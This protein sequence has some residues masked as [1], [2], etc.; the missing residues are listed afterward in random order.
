MCGIAGFWHFKTGLPATADAVKA[1]TDR[2]EHRGPDGGGEYCN[3]DLGLGQRRLSIIDLAGGHQPMANA[4]EDIWVVFNGEIFNHRALRAELEADGVRFRTSSDT[5]VISHCYQKYGDTFS[6]ALN[7]FFAIALW[8]VKRQR[9]ILTRDRLGK[10]PLLIAHTQHG[11]AFASEMQALSAA[12]GVSKTLDVNGLDAFVSYGYV[13]HRFS[14]YKGVTKL[15]PATT[16]SI[17]RDGAERQQ[18]Y[19]QIEHK[20]TNL[21]YEDAKSALSEL[22]ATAVADRLESDV[23][24]GAF[25]S[26]GIDSTTIA[27]Y[28]SEQSTEQL[29][30][31]CVGFNE[32]RFDERAPARMVAEWLGT[33]HRESVVDVDAAAVLPKLL[34]HYGEPYSDAS[35]IP[36]YFL[37]SAVR[38]HMT[39]ALSGDGGD[40][41]FLGYP[42]YPKFEKRLKLNRLLNALPGSGLIADVARNRSRHL[43]NLPERIINAAL[44]S[45][46]P[47]HEA[48]ARTVTTFVRGDKRELYNDSFANALTDTDN[49]DRYT[50]EVY[51]SH[52]DHD[53]ITRAGL[54]DMQV[55]MADDILAKVDISSM[56]ASLEVRA[57]LLD[58]RV[59]EFA[60][61]LPQE[62]KYKDGKGKRILRD[63]A[64]DRLPAELFSLP[65]SGFGIPV[66]DWLRGDMRDMVHDSLQ[67]PNSLIA[68]MFD[69]AAIDKMIDWHMSGKEG[70]AER[71]WKLMCLGVWAKNEGV[72]SL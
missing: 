50:S 23:P 12:E 53:Y 56:A 52:A 41:L 8:D 20:P 1:M 19:W 71:L 24:L 44:E 31:F 48:Y 63:I 66:S 6:K 72:R 39:V 15:A 45:A 21:S 68:D 26:G 38:E 57:P 65:K 60:A 55:Y 2:I 61:S 40:E 10:K 64:K 46:L 42:H 67:D 58:Y 11:I 62:Y 3:A 27:A 33:E 34:R 59:V 29:Q 4:E 69:R 35:T 5:E 28:A 43:R 25:L 7:G 13:P 9:L 17:E 49:V 22:I 32:R 18:C 51:A 36:T 30:T 54:T 37:C 14:T 16:L 47:V 70:Y